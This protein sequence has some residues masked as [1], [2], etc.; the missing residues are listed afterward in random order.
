[1]A[2]TPTL[3]ALLLTALVALPAV[4]EVT[5]PKPLLDPPTAERRAGGRQPGERQRPRPIAPTAAS[6]TSK[7][8]AP[9]AGRSATSAQ[10]AQAP[11]ERSGPPPQLVEHDTV[12][13][14]N[15][16]RFRGTV[17]SN[18]TDE[19]WVAINTG[20]G[21][22]RIRRE[23]VVRVE[24]GLTARMGQV[25][26]DD[27]AGLIDLARW[28]RANGRNPEAM[29][30]LT[31][32]VSLPACD[33]ESRGLYAQ[34]VDEL[35]GAEKAL[36]L[37][38]AYRNAGGTDADI[39]ARLVELETAHRVWEEQMRALGLD[40]GTS[41]ATGQPTA[42][43]TASSVDEGY[44]KYKWDPDS[45][46]WS[47][48]AKPSLITLVTPDGPRRVLQIDYEAHPTK[49]NIDKAAVVLRRPLALRADAKLTFLAANRSTKDVRIGI[50]VK[51]GTEWTYY[52][53]KPQVLKATSSGQEFAQLTFD[54]SAA[55]FKAQATNW[56]H[57]ARIANL[58]QVRELQI[59]FHNGRNDGSVWIAGLNFEGGA[60]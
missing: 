13:L 57:S 40:P 3:S 10:S 21:I 24:Y 50:A 51:T 28:C 48:P 15:E 14:D 55:D 45:A 11:A 16:Q 27:V 47:S 33:L 36:P 31:K 30:L 37:Y 54:L 17:L 6:E 60:P 34:L 25:K 7:P 53:S 26:S 35:D 29:Q 4:E 49:P 2:M 41:A 46:D 8:G 44:E 12:I 19:D 5:P 42:A 52:E 23:R 56:A 58:E 22:M 20:N 59:L 43:A 32:A 38:V 18:Q 39:L 1:M 9:P